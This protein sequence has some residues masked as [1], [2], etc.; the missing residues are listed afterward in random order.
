MKPYL[1]FTFT[2][3]LISLTGCAD[4]T[5][6]VQR[7]I[8]KNPALFDQLSEAHKRL[9]VQGEIENGMRK[10]AVFLAWGPPDS[11]GRGQKDGKDT[12]IWYYGGAYDRTAYYD[13]YVTFGF[14]H[15]YGGGFGY[16]AYYGGYPDPLYPRDFY[17]RRAT[18]TAYVS[19]S[20]NKVIEW[21][22]ERR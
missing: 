12:D 10:D 14:G 9:V 17:Y 16:G 4:E 15:G 20:A 2:L 19:F 5:T 6:S 13:P 18:P 11:T 7:R 22:A 8:N 21:Q 3:L 1:L